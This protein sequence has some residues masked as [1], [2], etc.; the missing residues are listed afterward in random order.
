V[1]AD[2]FFPQALQHLRIVQHV[3]LGRVERQIE[4]EIVRAPEPVDVFSRSVDQ[5]EGGKLIDVEVKA[6]ES[7]WKVATLDQLTPAGGP[8]ETLRNGDVERLEDRW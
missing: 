8:I 6:L 3:L 7:V 5:A 2:A 4:E 1:K